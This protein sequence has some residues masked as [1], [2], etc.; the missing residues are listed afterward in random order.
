MKYS[1]IFLE[2]LCVGRL[3][4]EG[5]NIDFQ[6]IDV[7]HYIADPKAGVYASG[8]RLI[9]ENQRLINN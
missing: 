3:S 1:D 5:Y 4:A 6:F 9:K 2:L 7:M 8:I